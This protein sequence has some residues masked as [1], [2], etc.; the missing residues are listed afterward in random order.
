MREFIKTAQMWQRK[1]ML[2]RKADVEVETTH[3]AGKTNVRVGAYLRDDK[4]DLA[5]DDKGEPICKIALLYYYDEEQD[6][7]DDLAAV[8]D[9]L[10]NHKAI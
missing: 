9:F 10:T 4:G 3:F 5:R 7:R 6:C 8:G 1:A 2:K